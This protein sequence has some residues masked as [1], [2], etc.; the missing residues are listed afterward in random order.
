MLQEDLKPED[1]A[2]ILDDLKAGKE[3]KP[4]PRSVNKNLRKLLKFKT[5]RNYKTCW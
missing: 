4:G 5:K 3:P 1:M 2:E